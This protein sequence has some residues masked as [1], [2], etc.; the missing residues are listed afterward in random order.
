[1]A[2][3]P[4][5]GGISVD[6]PERARFVGAD[7]VYPL[8]SGVQGSLVLNLDVMGGIPES[9][10]FYGRISVCGKVETEVIFSCSIVMDFDGRV[11]DGVVSGA[12]LADG[13]SAG[14]SMNRA[15]L[16]RIEGTPQQVAVEAQLPI[17]MGGYLFPLGPQTFNRLSADDRTRR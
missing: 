5:E 17:R 15:A 11:V 2:G 10:R 7:S 14:G 6:T 16:L 1:M 3:K 8:G 13:Y 9:G 12:G 4:G